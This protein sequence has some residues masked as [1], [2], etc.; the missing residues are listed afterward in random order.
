MKRYIHSW[1]VWPM[2]GSFLLFIV[3][4]ITAHFGSNDYMMTVLII[5]S[6][7]TSLACV[8]GNDFDFIGSTNGSITYYLQSMYRSL[9]GFTL[10]CFTCAF[11]IALGNKQ[12]NLITL[13]LSFV[14]S[15]FVLSMI[16]IELH[17]KRY[18]GG[19]VLGLTLITGFFVSHLVLILGLPLAFIVS[20]ISIR[21]VGDLT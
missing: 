15:S 20:V 7:T 19:V 16:S 2:F 8:F 17:L 10:L 13:A 21:K 6:F 1:T 11:L 3:M 18:W 14:S 9:L 12:L 5:A 4:S